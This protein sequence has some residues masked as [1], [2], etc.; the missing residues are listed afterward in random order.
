[1]ADMICMHCLEEFPWQEEMCDETCPTCLQAGHTTSWSPSECEIC[2]KEYFDAIAAI[3]AGIDFR[4]SLIDVIEERYVAS[5][6]G[7]SRCPMCLNESCTNTRLCDGCRDSCNK[8]LYDLI[9]SRT[10][11]LKSRAQCV[12]PLNNE[13]T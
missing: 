1:M 5:G 10:N 6:A 8:A 3:K 9:K 4:V 11:A 7:H 13:A 12:T 2:N